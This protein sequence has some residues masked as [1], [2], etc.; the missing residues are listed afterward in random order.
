[1]LRRGGTVGLIMD[2]RVRPGQGMVLP[3][4]GQP[5]LTTSLPASLSLRTGAPAVPLFAYPEP[6]GTYRVEALPAIAPE[7]EGEEA[8][9]RLTAR[10]LAVIEAQIRAHPEQWLWLHRR[11]R[12]D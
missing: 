3:F 4:F 8:V 10:Y 1:V 7:G 2:Q 12:L 6:R 9:A 5:A 11:W